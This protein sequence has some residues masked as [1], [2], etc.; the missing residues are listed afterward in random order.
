MAKTI[1]SLIA[2]EKQ[3]IKDYGEKARRV[4]APAAKVIRHIQGEERQ[5]A[6]EL[7]RVQSMQKGIR[8]LGSRN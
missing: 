2:D 3:A 4:S 1:P 7:G 6:Q 8:K 5:H